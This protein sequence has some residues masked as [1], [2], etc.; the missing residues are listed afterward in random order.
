[1]K[2]FFGLGGAAG[3]DGLFAAGAGV[4]AAAAASVASVSGIAVPEEVE[5]VC[6]VGAVWLAGG[7]GDGLTA[8]DWG[9]MARR[10][11]LPS[12]VSCAPG[13]SSKPPRLPQPARLKRSRPRRKAKINL[14]KDKPRT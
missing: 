11:A 13:G 14:I 4:G 3:L 5:D 9:L 7:K 6:N 8:V 10:A 1:M 12:G 2:V